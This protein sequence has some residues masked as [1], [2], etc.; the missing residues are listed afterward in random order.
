MS[1]VGCIVS[2]CYSSRATDPS[3]WPTPGV[4]SATIQWPAEVPLITVEQLEEAGELLA[5]VAGACGLVLLSTHGA[6]PAESLAGHIERVRKST[7]LT[8]CCCVTPRVSPNVRRKPMSRRSARDVTMPTMHAAILQKACNI[9]EWQNCFVT[10]ED[11][12]RFSTQKQKG[13]SILDVPD[14]SQAVKLPEVLVR[15]K[16]ETAFARQFLTSHRHNDALAGEG[17]RAS[18]TW[19]STGTYVARFVCPPCPECGG[20]AKVERTAGR[21]RHIKCRSGSCGHRWKVSNSE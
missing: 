14:P 12:R 21:V 8:G 4:W 3:D 18:T 16:G 11:F 7:S 15:L 2:A 19:E 13:Q 1:K 9:A 6:L 20:K 17:K 5:E 10:I